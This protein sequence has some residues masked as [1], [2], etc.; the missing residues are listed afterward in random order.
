MDA[1]KNIINTDLKNGLTNIPSPQDIILKFMNRKIYKG[2]FIDFGC[3]DGYFTFTAESFFTNVIG[4][5]LSM[6][7]INNLLKTRP[8]HSEAKF[9]RSNNYFTALPDSSADVIFMF[10]ILKKVPDAKKFIKEIKRLLKEDGELWVL[11][12][13]NTNANLSFYNYFIPKEK[14]ITT[15]NDDELQFIE[16]IDISENYYGVKFTKKRRFI[17]AFLS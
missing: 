14:L 16:Y 15:L 9:I 6:S 3:N 11:E 7:I 10:H 5:D 8:E 17:Y 1:N 12:P 2:T 13:E 4:V